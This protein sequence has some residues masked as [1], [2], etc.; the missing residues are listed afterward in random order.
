VV[1]APVVCDEKV[2]LIALYAVST[3]RFAIAV[4]KLR[5][6]TDEE[7]DEYFLESEAARIEC[8]RARHTIQKHRAEH[9]C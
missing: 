9:C 5:T 4:A 3:Q 2:R 8:G 6:T 7:F 1:T